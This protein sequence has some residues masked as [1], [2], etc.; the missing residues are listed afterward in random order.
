VGGCF[1][2]DGAGSAA[3]VIVVTAAGGS[4]FLVADFVPDMHH[5]LRHRREFE[6]TGA[7]RAWRPK[8]GHIYFGESAEQP[9]PPFGATKKP[10]TRRGQPVDRSSGAVGAGGVLRQSARERRHGASGRAERCESRTAAGRRLGLRGA[11][12]AHPLALSH[13]CRRLGQ[14]ALLLRDDIVIMGPRSAP[15]APCSARW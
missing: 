11:A 13:R 10:T 12:R 2:S 5:T 1:R 7:V 3:I 9:F 14:P 4:I 8:S 6:L 15:A